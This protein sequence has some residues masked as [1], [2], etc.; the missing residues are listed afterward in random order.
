MA[1]TQAMCTS[2]K[3]ELF[4]STHNFGSGTIRGSTAA[5]VF[6]AALYYSSATLNATTTVYSSA[7]EVS[8]TGYTPGGVVITNAVAPTTSG[9]TAYWTPSAYIESPAMSIPAP[10]D[11]VL[12]YN[13]TQANKA[14]AVYTFS[15]QTVSVG[16]FTLVTPANVAGTAM[17]NL[18]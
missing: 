13:A 4:T 12:I 7:G 14:V 1:N 3:N 10:F 9:A 18:A 15:P 5:D 16:T 8:G 11:C 17:L 2:F 6:K